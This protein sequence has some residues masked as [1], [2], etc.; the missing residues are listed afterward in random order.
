MRREANHTPPPPCTTS[1][2]AG[3]HGSPRAW[4]GAGSG[5]VRC[6]GGHH[7]GLP[8]GDGARPAGRIQRMPP[9]PEGGSAVRW[10][11]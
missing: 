10:G 7:V 2:D 6:G 11:N 5:G 3:V 4:A 1:I 9:P 8:V